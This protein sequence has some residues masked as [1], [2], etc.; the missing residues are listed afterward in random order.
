MKFLKNML[1]ILLSILAFLSLSMF[2]LLES[3]VNLTSKKNIS[4][5]V[6]LV[7]LEDIVDD[8]TYNSISDALD[9]AGLSSEYVDDIL[10]NDDIK[11]IVSEYI[12]DSAESLITDGELPEMDKD[13]LQSTIIN[14]IDSVASDARD[15]GVN[16]SD[17]DINKVKDE[18]NSNIDVLVDEFNEQSKKFS[19][20]LKNGTDYQYMNKILGIVRI[21]YNN[22]YLYLVCSVVC[23]ILIALINIKNYA[24]ISVLSSIFMVYGFF[25]LVVGIGLMIT[26]NLLTSTYADITSLIA[27][28]NSVPSTYLIYGISLLLC[29]IVLLLV[30]IIIN[31]NI[32]NKVNKD[33]VINN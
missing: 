24:Y 29:G 11:D 23:I 17:E 20:E 14:A 10:K 4:N 27:C 19:D 9:D 30:K 28:L 12:S 2:I 22:R 5:I 33:V 6:S 13:K 18:V 21:L 7:S 32:K 1:T 31:K 15:N 25:N 8:D 26:F 16:I 3:T